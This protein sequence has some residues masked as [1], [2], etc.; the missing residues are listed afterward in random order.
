M[1]AACVVIVTGLVLPS[2]AASVPSLFWTK[3]CVRECARR[4]VARLAAGDSRSSQASQATQIRP[5]TRYRSGANQGSRYE[6]AVTCDEIDQAGMPPLALL[7]AVALG[8]TG[9]EYRIADIRH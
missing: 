7:Q 9:L 6:P 1:P 5:S 8:I 2:E 4:L 3:A